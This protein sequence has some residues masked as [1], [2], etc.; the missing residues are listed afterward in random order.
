MRRREGVFDGGVLRVEFAGEIGLG[1]GV[2]VRREMVA[3]IAEGTDPDLGGEV[4]AG[5]GVE[6]GGA[7]FAA[8]RG[9]R[10]ARDVGVRADHG[11]GGR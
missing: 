3:L 2:V 1:D 6:G 7:G 5:E 11:D 10:E 4:D 8:E 9:V